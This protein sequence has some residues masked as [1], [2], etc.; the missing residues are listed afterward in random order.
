MR[1]I[2]TE[3]RQQSLHRHKHQRSIKDCGGKKNNIHIVNDLL[4]PS[5]QE[6]SLAQKHCDSKINIC[7]FTGTLSLEWDSEVERTH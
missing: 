6:I 2:T 7:T 1:L 5:P 4:L 3:A